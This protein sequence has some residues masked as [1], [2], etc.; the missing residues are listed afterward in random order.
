MSHEYCFW[1]RYQTMMWLDNFRG[2]VYIPCCTLSI[3]IF[4]YKACAIALNFQMF[5]LLVFQADKTHLMVDKSDFA[6]INHENS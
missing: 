5:I 2:H 3:T 1:I 6:E 4:T